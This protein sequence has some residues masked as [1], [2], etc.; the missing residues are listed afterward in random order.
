MFSKLL[1]YFS[2]LGLLTFLCGYVYL[3]SYME[4]FNIDPLAYLSNTELMYPLLPLVTL[5]VSG[6]WGLL[7]PVHRKK[8][9]DPLKPAKGFNVSKKGVR[10]LLVILSSLLIILILLQVLVKVKIFSADLLPYLG[11]VLVLILVIFL[12][13][14]EWTLFVESDFK[15]PFSYLLFFAGI[16]FFASRIGSANAYSKLNGKPNRSYTFVFRGKTVSTDDSLIL[17]KESQNTLFLYDK[18]NS[19]THIYKRDEVDSLTVK[20]VNPL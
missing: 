18:R 2:L 8:Q 1:Q 16:L 10:T 17:V 12:G 19:S 6:F 4:V 11:V 7:Q 13:Q 9:L 5:L 20:K 3:D 15:R 14:Q